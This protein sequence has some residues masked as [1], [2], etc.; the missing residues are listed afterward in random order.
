MAGTTKLMPA[1]IARRPTKGAKGRLAQSD[2][3][4]ALRPKLSEAA[5][6]Q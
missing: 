1:N 5:M 2:A 4:A 6:Q 3:K